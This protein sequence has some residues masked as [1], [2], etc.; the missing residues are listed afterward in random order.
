MFGWFAPRCPL[1]TWE[2]TWA[3]TR[4]RWLA[5]RLGIDRLLKAA[6]VLPTPEFFPGP[7]G[8]T[9]EDARRMLERLCGHM[10]IDPATVELRVCLDEQMPEAA[11]LYQ[12]GRQRCR[13][14]VAQSQ[15]ADPMALLATLAHELSHELLLGGG[16]LDVSV[17]DHEWVT[18]L[19]PV[20]LGVG[21]FAANS[22]VHEQSGQDGQ[23]SWWVI[24]KEGYLPSRI[25]GYAMALFCFVRGETSPPWASHLR[26]DAAAP[27]REGLRYLAKT[28]GS[29]FHPDTVR[30]P[31]PPLTPATAGEGLRSGAPWIRLATL[32]RM[33]E[34]GLRAEECV[35]PVAGC[36]G[37]PDLDVQPEAARLLGGFGAAA[38]GAVPALVRSLYAAHPQTRAEAARALGELTAGPAVAPELCA[39]LGDPSPEVVEAAAEALGRLRQPLDERSL[40]RLIERLGS[41]LVD[42][43]DAGAE[44]FASALLAAAT[45]AEACVRRHLPGGLCREALRLLRRLRRRAGSLIDD[46]LQPADGDDLVPGQ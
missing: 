7:Y 45:D 34:E 20:F 32:W 19:L 17:E 23:T 42:C 29:L 33:A 22:T 36:L 6:V 28:G 31:L 27:L 24:R 11:G 13:I 41:A 18:D 44:A 38:A 12:Q 1:G 15:L 35:P 26:Q 25:F 30:E 9:A 2:K 5:D 8:G 37:D 40:A 4:M 46:V 10:G 39:L 14:R 3:E 43:D 16:L 21:I